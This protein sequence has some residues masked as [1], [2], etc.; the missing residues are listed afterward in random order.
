[1]IDD[2]ICTNLYKSCPNTKLHSIVLNCSFF[3]VFVSNK[4]ICGVEQLNL[5]VSLHE[6]CVRCDEDEECSL[7]LL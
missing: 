1:M 4:N 2:G 3:T 5:N 6:N 7:E